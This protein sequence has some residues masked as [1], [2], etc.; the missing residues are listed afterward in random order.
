MP[1]DVPVEVGT[2]WRWLPTQQCAAVMSP[3]KDVGVK[4]GRSGALTWVESAPAMRAHH[5]RIKIVP[6]GCLRM[7]IGLFQASQSLS[8]SRVHALQGLQMFDRFQQCI[9]GC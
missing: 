8:H 9:D 1:H 7:A 3:C 2:G 5:A 6:A 4:E